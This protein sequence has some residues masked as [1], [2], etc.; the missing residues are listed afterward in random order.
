[1]SEINAAN[2]PISRKAPRVAFV[3]GG[4]RGLGRAV[5]LRLL[6]EGYQVGFT[7]FTAEDRG[8][9]VLA[10]AG[11]AASRCLALRCDVRVE[12]EV[13]AAISLTVSHFGGLSAVIA[14]A[15][16]N[17]DGMSWKTSGATWAEV[18]DTNLTGTFYTLKHA[19]P[20]LREQGFGRLLAM[21]SIVA[22]RGTIGTAAYAASKAGVLGLVRA[23]AAE[24]A[25]KQVTCN[26][27]IIGYMDEGMFRTM[28]PEHQ[29]AAVRQVPLGRPGSS[30]ELAALVAFLCSEEAGYIT[31]QAIPITGGLQ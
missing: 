6:A 15:G 29:E 26:A 30:E 27:L 16:V 20:T 17:R 14:N 8:E 28:R 31:G 11:S 13:A 1:M 24:A 22:Q 25:S 7:Y 3:T 10:A 19:L 23:I 4:S 21:S 2:S 18:L 5:V 9:E 12:E